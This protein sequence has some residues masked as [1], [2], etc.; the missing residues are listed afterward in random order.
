[1]KDYLYGRDLIFISRITRDGSGVIPCKEDMSNLNND[2]FK[3]ISLSITNGT[4]IAAEMN[5]YVVKLK[6]KN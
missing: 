2:R 6:T 5:I 1:M 3:M 4:W